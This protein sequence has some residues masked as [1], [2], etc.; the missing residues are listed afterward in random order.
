MILESPLRPAGRPILRAATMIVLLAW[1]GFVLT[2]TAG[3]T[4]TALTSQMIDDHAKQIVQRISAYPSADVDGD[5]EISFE[6]RN[7]FLVAL[8]HQNPEAGLNSY[9]YSDLWRGR[10]LNLEEMYDVVRGLSFRKKALYGQ[11]ATYVEAREAGAS[12]AELDKIKAGLEQKELAGV[13]TV[14]QGQDALLDSMTVEPDAQVV[15][16]IH[17]KITA[18]YQ[19]ESLFKLQEKATIYEE[20][21]A[22]LEQMGEQEKA[23]ELRSELESIQKKIQQIESK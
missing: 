8:F 19:K 15:A 4:E 5:G 17:M 16:K 1:S 11:K 12:Q 3:T 18:K 2:G 21:I 6:E 10:E 7:A 20:K 23:D 14:L 13:E 22:K 9:S